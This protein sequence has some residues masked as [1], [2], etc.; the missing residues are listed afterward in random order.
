MTQCP[1]VSPKS[2]NTCLRSKVSPGSGM[3]EG[4]LPGGSPHQHNTE[5]T[6]K[7][8][9]YVKSSTEIQPV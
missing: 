7:E 9:V 4:K 8:T 1:E 2:T 5:K 3:Q 6:T